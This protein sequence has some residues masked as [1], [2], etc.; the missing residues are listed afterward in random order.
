MK[1]NFTLYV[2][3][4]YFVSI[5]CS[6][7]AATPPTIQLDQYEVDIRPLHYDAKKAAEY[8]SLQKKS[9]AIPLT[10]AEHNLRLEILG[11]ALK[12]HPKW[13]DGYWMLATDA[14]FLG[15]QLGFDKDYDGAGKVL[16]TGIKATDKCL[17]IDKN[18]SLCGFF[19]AALLAK[20]A[21]IKGIFSS[22]SY[23]KV[24]RDQWLKVI[25]Q[26]KNMAF[27][28]NVSLQ[29]SAYYGLGLFF[30]LVPDFFLVEWLWGIRGNLDRSI[31]YHRKA[32]EFDQ[33]NPCAQLMLA[34]ALMC[35]SKGKKEA[36]EYEEALSYFDK[37]LKLEPIDISQKICKTDAQILRFNPDKNCGYTQAKYHKPANKEELLKKAKK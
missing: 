37:T 15:T 25:Q 29:G 30:R 22:L 13:L 3:F 36:R 17:S 11:E 23:G 24:V 35:K 27:R 16:E 28:S 6:I 8:I 31:E 9:E 19:H 4:S 7:L 26:D 34:V 2:F 12:R 5:H 32:A 1:K 33:T 18:N 21:S 10:A 20:Y 14:F